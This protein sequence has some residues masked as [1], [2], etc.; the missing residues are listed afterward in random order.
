VEVCS[1]SLGMGISK[2]RG[3]A[4]GKKMGGLGGRVF[5]LLGD[6][7]LQEGQ[8][9][10]SLL[11][12]SHLATD[13]TVIV[14]H[15]KIQTDLPVEEMTSLGDLTE[16]FRA[17]GAVVERCDG[18][19]PVAL[20]DAWKRLSKIQGP[21]VLI[22]DTVKGRGVSFMEKISDMPSAQGK[23]LWHS[24]APSDDAF[25]KAFDELVGVVNESFSRLGLAIP[26]LSEKERE[27]KGPT[28]TYKHYVAAGYGE[29]LVRLGEKHPEMVV[30]DGDLAADCRLR[31]FQEKY[32]DRFI[33]NGI[34]EQDMVSAAGGLARQGFVPVVNSFASFLTSRANEQI[35]NN[36]CEGSKIIYAAHFAGM[37]PA[38]PGKSHQSV[39]DIAL[40][41]SIPGLTIFQPCNPEEAAMALRYFVEDH[42]GASVLRMN[43]G[44]SPREILLPENY[45]IKLGRG[46][47]LREGKSAVVV[48]Y[49]PVMLHEVLSAAELLSEEG[50]HL[51]VVSMPW[52]NQPNK[53]WVVGL[54]ETYS[55]CFVIEDHLVEGGLGGRMGAVIHERGLKE[56]ESLEILG[57]T[58][59]PECGTPMEVLKYHELDGA[60]LARK[61]FSKLMAKDLKV[62]A[63]VVGE[64]ILEAAQ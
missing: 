59:L 16:K 55:R 11:K 58:E 14:D 7:E 54:M 63:G 1:G 19:D 28:L 36:A 4:Q 35:Y 62:R 49:G 22:A 21:K 60:S 50:V 24:G 13:I 6:G 12:A 64:D 46:V 61:I 23:Y 8:I 27:M 25:E 17:F 41:A 20:H 5:V 2:A 42:T 9:W 56:G 38:G 32:P 30:M 15:N 44:P 33:E 52:L 40:M 53:E 45:E 48:A 43:I 34:A 57:I 51:A 39:R 26:S 10:E 29:E 47:L 3:L 31:A 18:H 37:I